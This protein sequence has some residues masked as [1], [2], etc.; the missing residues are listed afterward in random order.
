MKDFIKCN[1]KHNP[2]K[3]CR[4]FNSDIVRYKDLLNYENYK[5][6]SKIIRKKLTKKSRI[7][8][9]L[10]FPKVLKKLKNKVN[11]FIF[12]KKNKKNF[13][14]LKEEINYMKKLL[15]KKKLSEQKEQIQITKNQKRILNE[16][17]KHLESLSAAQK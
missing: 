13:K 16:K 6:E 5:K 14:N 9:K 1:A 10:Y 11:K 15:K 12:S 3:M 17:I 7:I 2:L 8:N 4:L